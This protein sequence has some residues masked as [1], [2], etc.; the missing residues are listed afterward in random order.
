MESM[1]CQFFSERTRAFSKSSFPSAPAVLARSTFVFVV[2]AGAIRVIAPRIKMTPT[3]TA[4]RI[5]MSDCPRTHLKRTSARDM[6]QFPQDRGARAKACFWP[7]ESETTRVLRKLAISRG[8]CGSFPVP[9]RCGFV[10]VPQG[11]PSSPR[12]ADTG[13]LLA[14]RAGGAFEMG[15]KKRFDGICL[16][17]LFGD[18][19]ARAHRYTRGGNHNI[20]GNELKHDRG[21]CGGCAGNLGKGNVKGSPFRQA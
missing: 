11:T 4:T 21:R 17:Y 15:S 7:S 16:L 20:P 3:A 10:E 12:L 19:A 14:T 1:A 6:G 2:S 8:G 5:S 13:K 18:K 9:L